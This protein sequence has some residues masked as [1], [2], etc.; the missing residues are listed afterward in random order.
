M[1][2]LI[3]NISWLKNK[4]QEDLLVLPRYLQAKHENIFAQPRVGASKRGA[5]SQR[6]QDNALG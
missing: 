3:E 6:K 1:N 2:P 4:V 5:E